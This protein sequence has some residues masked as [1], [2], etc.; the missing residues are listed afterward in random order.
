MMDPPSLAGQGM[1]WLSSLPG[2]CNSLPAGP[3]HSFGPAL[4]GSPCSGHR[5]AQA[6]NLLPL[7]CGPWCLPQGPAPDELSMLPGSP[8]SSHV[9]FLFLAHTVFFPPHFPEPLVHVG[10]SAHSQQSLRAVT[11]I[12]FSSEHPLC[13]KLVILTIGI[14]I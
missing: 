11:Y 4:F 1:L 8:G 3:R 7:L 10:V 2:C 14:I 5:N 13:L 6:K 9:A 12:S